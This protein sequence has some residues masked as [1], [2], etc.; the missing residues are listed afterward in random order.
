MGDVIAFPEFDNVLMC[1]CGCITFL[2]HATG[3]IECAGCEEIQ[4]GYDG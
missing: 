4:G 1:E 2:L 3:E